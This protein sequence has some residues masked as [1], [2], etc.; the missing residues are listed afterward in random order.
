MLQ[1]VVSLAKVLAPF[2]IISFIQNMAFTASSRSRNSKDPNYHRWCAYASN[3]VFY[4]TNALLTVYII[5]YGALWQLAIQ[6][7]IYTL[8]T[9]EGSVFMMKEMI[10]REKGKQTPGFVSKEDAEQLKVLIAEH[11]AAQAKTNG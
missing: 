6:G 8:A 9:A 2:G 7:V 5:K 10:K 11:N 3:G 4:V 1:A